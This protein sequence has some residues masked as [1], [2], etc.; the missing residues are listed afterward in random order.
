MMKQFFSFIYQY[1]KRERCPRKLSFSVAVSVFIAFSPFVGLHTVMALIFSW[2][3]ALNI[4]LL[5]VISNSINNPWTML[6]I[7]ATDHVVGDNLLSYLG[8]DGMQ[9]NPSWLSSINHWLANHTGIS[10]VSVGSF[11]IGGNILG[12][13]LALCVYLVVRWYLLMYRPQGV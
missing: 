12:F 4:G 10:G 2:V 13:I 1:L 9:L 8:I 7:Y 6:P 3:F 5:L 11:L